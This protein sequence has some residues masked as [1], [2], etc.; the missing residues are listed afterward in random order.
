MVDKGPRQQ[1]AS[2]MKGDVCQTQV[3]TANKKEIKDLVPV[4]VK[5]TQNYFGKEKEKKLPNV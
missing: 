1:V 3:C 4:I 2:S 5:P